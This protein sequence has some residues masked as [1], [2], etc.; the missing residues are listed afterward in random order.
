MQVYI[1]HYMN[2]TASKYRS[3]IIKH[4]WLQSKGNI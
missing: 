4:T 3:P 2:P 1:N